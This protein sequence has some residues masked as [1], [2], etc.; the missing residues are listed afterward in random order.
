MDDYKYELTEIGN[1]W[2]LVEIIFVSCFHYRDKIFLT[3]SVEY[4]EMKEKNVIKNITKRTQTNL[5]K[6]CR[7]ILV[8]R[9]IIIKV[10]SSIYQK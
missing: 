2:K 10:S 5:Y 8:S 4:V 1:L 7:L 6:K 3:D 9:I